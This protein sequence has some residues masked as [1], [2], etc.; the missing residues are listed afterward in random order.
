[1]DGLQSVWNL[2]E[3]VNGPINSFKLSSNSSTMAFTVVPDNKGG[4]KPLSR[5]IIGDS[6]GSVS[7]C[8]L[9]AS[10]I[11]YGGE[12]EMEQYLACIHSL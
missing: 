5:L 7:M 3:S 1:M 8:E 2:L 6:D 4:V 10:M 11:D 12:E 9:D